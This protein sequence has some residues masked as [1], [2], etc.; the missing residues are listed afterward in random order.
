MDQLLKLVRTYRLS[1]G[2]AERLTLGDE[3]F[4]VVEPQLRLFI[5]GMLARPAA[6]DVL[7]EALKAVALSLGRFEGK[8]VAEFWGWCYRI[9]RNKV[10]DQ[11]R[12]RASDKSEPMP[13]EELWRLADAVSESNAL[14]PADRLDLEQAMEMLSQAKP[15]CYD[16][17]T[18]HFIFGLDY[19]EIAEEQKLSYDNVRMRIGR[20]L[21]HAQSL[22]S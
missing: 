2:L 3:I 22:I 11:L 17:L 5:F 15:E 20:C 19:A 10:N 21:D 13:P 7:Q 18:K 14:S 16:Y 9:A 6:E 4:R 1:E 12:A 8:S